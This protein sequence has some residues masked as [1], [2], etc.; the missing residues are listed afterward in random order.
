MN[1]DQNREGDEEVGYSQVEEVAVGGGVHALV[2]VD[3]DAGEDVAHEA[4]HED[5]EQRYREYDFR[6]V[7]HFTESQLYIVVPVFSVIYVCLIHCFG[8]LELVELLITISIYHVRVTHEL[9]ET[10]RKFT[11]STRGITWSTELMLPVLVNVYLI[12][13]ISYQRS[14]VFSKVHKRLTGLILGPDAWVWV[15]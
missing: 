3:D 10:S 9:C 11:S 14:S 5:D 1:D 7:G 8:F 2:V 12:R 13:Y 6:T 4:G 15:V